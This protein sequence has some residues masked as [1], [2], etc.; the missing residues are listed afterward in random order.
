MLKNTIHLIF[1][2]LILSIVSCEE[3][4]TF[5][6]L[7][8][9]LRKDAKIKLMA[10]AG[11]D[12][13]ETLKTSRLAKDMKI[14][15]SILIGSEKKIKEL[16]KQENIEIS[17]FKIVNSED[18][19]EISKYAAK[20]V[21]DGIADMYVKGS[22]E[23]RDVLKAVLDQEIG[24]RTNDIISL[25]AVFEIRK[26]LWFFTD[27]SVVPYPNLQNKV[28][29]IHNAVKFARST[30]IKLPKVAVVTA[31]SIVNPRMPETVE[32]KQLATM[33]EKGKIK[34]CIIDGPLSFDLA[35]SPKSAFIK[36]S[37]RKINGDADIILFPDVHAANISYK[38]LTQLGNGKIG[39]ILLGTSKPVILSSRSDSVETKLN[40][41]ILGFTYDKFNAERS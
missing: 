4:I 8:E 16:A 9:N 24:L 11:A 32:A 37:K 23:T 10:V 5:D 30:G 15:D 39:N 17:D 28:Q 6:H 21:H 20:M 38:I 13:P 33:N 18:N 27:P 40:S 25:V 26:K 3:Q 36:Q 14:C 19:V 41:I 7:L 35:I 34:D 2:F 31:L 22:I 1:I 29:L 12:N